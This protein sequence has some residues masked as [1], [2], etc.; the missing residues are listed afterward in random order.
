MAKKKVNDAVT[1]VENQVYSNRVA[2]SEFDKNWRVVVTISGYVSYIATANQARV[3]V[4]LTSG[5]SKL[6][7]FNKGGRVLVGSGGVSHYSKPHKATD[8]VN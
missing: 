7:T 8:L 1:R 2:R 5:A 6:L 3:V 4:L